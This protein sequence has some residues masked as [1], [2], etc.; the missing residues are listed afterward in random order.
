MLGLLDGGSPGSVLGRLA[1]ARLGPRRALAAREPLVCV[2]DRLQ[3]ATKQGET[4]HGKIA[5]VR[6]HGRNPSTRPV[7]KGG[8]RA[9]LEPGC[10]LRASGTTLRSCRLGLR[11]VHRGIYPAEKACGACTVPPIPW[12]ESQASIAAPQPP[13]GC[14]RPPSFGT[15][16]PSDCP[17]PSRFHTLPSLLPTG[18]GDLPLPFLDGWPRGIQP[19]PLESEVSLVSGVVGSWMSQLDMEL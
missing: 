9:G 17:D 19:F 4:A 16:P 6:R 12:L 8:G 14:Q 3:A 10:S 11:S 18:C 7:W 5:D 1:A 2:A 13:S 15:R